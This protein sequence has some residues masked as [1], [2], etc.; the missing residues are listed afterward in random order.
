[1][2]AWVQ[3]VPIDRSVYGRIMERLGDEV[4]DGLLLHVAL[5]REGGTLRYLDVWADR[6]S[7]DRFTDERLHPAV[8]PVLHEAGVHPEVEPP[9]VEVELVHM[10]G[11]ALREPVSQ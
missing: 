1:M 2:Y 4:P 6:E 11:A 10:W 9:R 8:R 7:C 5:G 3:D